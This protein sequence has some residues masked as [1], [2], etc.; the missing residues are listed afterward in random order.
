[1]ADEAAISRLYAGIHFPSDNNQGIATGRQ[2]GQRV[3]DYAR[4]DGADE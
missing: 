2:I 3:V 1:M 4:H